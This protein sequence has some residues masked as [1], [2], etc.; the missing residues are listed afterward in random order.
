MSYPVPLESR[1]AVRKFLESS[2]ECGIPETE[3]CLEEL[4]E[5]TQAIQKV[6]RAHV[7]GNEKEARD[8]LAMEIAHV[9]LTLN[10]LR[11]QE[12]IPLVEIQNYMDLKIDEWGF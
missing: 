3:Y 5:L 8:N 9:Y 6:K 2:K 7:F 12:H 11:E 10:H 4:A 1:G